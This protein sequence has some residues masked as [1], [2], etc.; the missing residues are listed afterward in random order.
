LKKNVSVLV[1]VCVICSSTIAET[2]QKDKPDCDSVLNTCLDYSKILEKERD[3]YRDAVQLQRERIQ[4]LER[5]QP[6]QPWYFWL[7]LGAAS[8]IVID[9]VRR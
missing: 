8:A 2:G 9:G 7:V 1:L 4:E 6:S 3:L 5:T